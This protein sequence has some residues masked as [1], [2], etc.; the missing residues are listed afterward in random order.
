MMKEV[1]AE[2]RAEKSANDAKIKQLVMF[3]FVCCFLLLLIYFRE[4][5]SLDSA[6][7]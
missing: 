2:L 5:L 4:K 3:L 1:D 6:G 7:S